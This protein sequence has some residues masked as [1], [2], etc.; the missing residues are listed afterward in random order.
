MEL[1][2][3]VKFTLPAI[4]NLETIEEYFIA[5]GYPHKVDDLREEIL[6]LC[7]LLSRNPKMGQ[8]EFFLEHLNQGHRYLLVNPHYK[9]IYFETVNF[10]FIID[11]FDTRQNPEKLKT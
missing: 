3:E 11:V 7:D 8:I 9:L 5:S 6:R 1:Y 4:K 10:V 2:K